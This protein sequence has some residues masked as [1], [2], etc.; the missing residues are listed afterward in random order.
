MILASKIL[1]K[2]L[3]P[4]LLRIAVPGKSGSH[5]WG[6]PLVTVAMKRS[7]QHLILN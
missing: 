3:S 5:G 7:G 6:A 4:F 2:S 1:K